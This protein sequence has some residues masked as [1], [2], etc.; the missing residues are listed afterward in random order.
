[1]NYRRQ[2]TVG[3]SIGNILLDFTG[4]SLSILQ[5]FLL[6]YNNGKSIH[7]DISYIATSTLHVVEI[8]SFVPLYHSL[9]LSPCHNT[10][11]PHFNAVFPFQWATYSFQILL[12]R[13]WKRHR[14]WF[15]YDNIIKMSNNLNI[16]IIWL[17]QWLYVWVCSDW[18]RSTS[19]P[20]IITLHEVII[21]GVLN[22]KIAALAYTS[23]KVNIVE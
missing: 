6:A 11:L 13:T 2:S 16:L 1:M 19:Y 7:H 5:M 12:S 4:G 3:W 18:Q 10:F 22:F 23:G 17:L 15:I 14:V 8:T 20:T 9:P 21:A